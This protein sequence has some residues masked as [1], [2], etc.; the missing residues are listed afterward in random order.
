MHWTSVSMQYT[1][2][3]TLSV[4]ECVHWTDRTFV[5][6]WHV[7]MSVVCLPSAVAQRSASWA[8]AP[9][10]RAPVPWPRNRASHGTP[11][12]SQRRY[13]SRLS[14]R[15]WCAHPLGPAT[16]RMWS[17]QG[18]YQRCLFPAYLET[19]FKGPSINLHSH[20]KTAASPNPYSFV[21]IPILHC[22]RMPFFFYPHFVHLLSSYPSSL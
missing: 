7:G 19:S 16:F 11:S 6:H 20:P 21:T 1:T 8:I 2:Q 12:L 15:A 13:E 3:H 22:L 17:L 10:R 14:P 18:S 9:S 4:W 5:S